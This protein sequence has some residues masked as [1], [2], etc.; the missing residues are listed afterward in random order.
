MNNFGRLLLTNIIVIIVLIGG[1]ALGFY[2][3]DQSANYV[4]TDNA[5]IDG[6]QIAIAPS[7]N[8]KLTE[9]N[10]T[11][12]QTFSA[13]DTVGQI[14]TQ[15]AKGNNVQVPVTMPKNGTIAL[16][17]AVKDTFVAA[18]SPL[19][20]AYDYNALYVTANIKETDI[21]DIS[22]GQKVDIYVDAYKGTTLTGRVKE[23]GF[24]TSGNF[25]L[26]ST[27]NQS[28]NYT[29]V[30]QVIPVKISIDSSKGVQL[31]PGMNVTVRIHT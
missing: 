27:T 16:N 19:A 26:L 20:Y 25:S 14:T 15:D 23:I 3:Y 17:N 5:K 24:A 28:G 2:F 8:G 30:V 22:T 11:E 18:G 12:G 10:G 31:R 29:K 7:T 6:Q 9:W 4:K 21:D 1:G 13:G